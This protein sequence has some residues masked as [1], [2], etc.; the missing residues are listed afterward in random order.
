MWQ[1]VPGV[2][3]VTTS[4]RIGACDNQCQEW[5]MWQPVPGLAHVTTSARSGACDNQCQQWRMWQPVPGMVHVT[6]SARTGACDNQCQDWRMWQPVPGVAHMTTSVRSGACDNQCQRYKHHIKVLEY[7]YCSI[8]LSFLSYLLHVLIVNAFSLILC[9]PLRIIRSHLCILSHI[10]S[11]AVPNNIGLSFGLEKRKALLTFWHRNFTF[12]SNKSP[13][14]FNSISVYYPDVCLQLNM[15]L[16]FSRPSSGAQWP[17]W[18]PLVLP[19]CRGDSRA[20]FVVEPAGQPARPDHEHGTTITT[21][22]R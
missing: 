10:D 14:W 4:A 20:V 7:R 3:H 8:V 11:S 15:F 18:Q 16:A 21:I 9:V 5:R 2:A 6:T 19:S 17:H 12:N 13:T 1:P 22:R